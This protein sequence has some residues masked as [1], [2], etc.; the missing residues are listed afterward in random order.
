MITRVM[1]VLPAANGIAFPL[2]PLGDALTVDDL[3]QRQQKALEVEG[4]AD[5]MRVFGVAARLFSRSRL[6]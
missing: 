5:V 1:L 6:R 3:D 2:A 4:K